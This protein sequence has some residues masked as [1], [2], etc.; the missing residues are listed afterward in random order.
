MSA[1]IAHMLIAEAAL[2]ELTDQPD[3]EKFK[4]V[5]RNNMPYYMLGSIGPDLPYYG[6]MFKGILNLL[7]DHPGKPMGVD[8]WSYQLHSK[9]LP[10]SRPIL[11]VLAVLKPA[12]VIY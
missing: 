3:F 4:D 11:M 8:Q 12:L 10:Q 9:T 7:L 5:I 2:N 1:S 6:S